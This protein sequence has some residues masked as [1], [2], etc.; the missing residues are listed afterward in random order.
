MPSKLES[1]QQEIRRI[2]CQFSEKVD[3]A[4]RMRDVGDAHSAHGDAHR[5]F[6]ELES[7]YEDLICEIRAEHRR[8]SIPDYD[9]SK[10]LP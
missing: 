7:A 3:Y 6:H 4:Y 1:L 9:P 10:R 5:L 8:D 2:S